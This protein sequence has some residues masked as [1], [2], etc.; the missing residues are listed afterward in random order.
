LG[1]YFGIPGGI[2]PGP[3]LACPPEGIIELGAGPPRPFTGPAKPGGNMEGAMPGASA[4]PRPAAL[5]TP[6]PVV[7]ST[8]ACLL[9]F[10]YV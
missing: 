1:G 3:Y 8:G 7:L 5:A 4:T 10:S 2:A 6:A 9:R